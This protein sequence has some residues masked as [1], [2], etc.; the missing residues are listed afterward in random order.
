MDFF[1]RTFG[2]GSGEQQQPPQ[3]TD[4]TEPAPNSE[5][6]VD[7]NTPQQSS[8]GIGSVLKSL[9]S[10]KLGSDVM[11]AVSLPA[12]LYEPLTI[13]QRSCETL[14]HS[15]L[16]DKAAQCQDPI[17]RLVWVAAFGISGYCGSE[18]FYTNFNPLLG[19]TFEFIDSQNGMKFIAEQV[20]H[21]PPITAS[22]AHNANFIFWQDTR[23]KTKFLGNSIEINT[24]A[25]THVQLPKTSDH[26]YY[27]CPLTRVHNLLIGSFWLEHYGE[28]SAANKLTND[29]CVIQFK[30]S[31]F[32]SRTNYEFEG[33]VK[34]AQGVDCVQLSGKWNEKIVAKWLVSTS[35]HAKDSE[36]VLFQVNTAEYYDKSKFRLT[37]FAHR[38][39]RPTELLTS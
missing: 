32:F 5:A 11:S 24:N 36:E 2:L 15:H 19:E 23:V 33:T 25:K 27:T 7:H 6:A 3:T 4:Q 35:E 34:N 8:Q 21:H 13:L 37:P 14:A 28:L 20:S 12:W 38:L 9:L 1:K 26:F 16:L 31:G 30:K 18:R 10:G 39:M 29:T 17:D 22:H